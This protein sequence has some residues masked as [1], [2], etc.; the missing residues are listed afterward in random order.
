[1]R[2][3]KAEN[4]VQVCVFCGSNPGGRPA[5][6]EAARALGSALVEAG[7]GLVFGGG[8]TG[9]MGAVANR[10]L[11]AGGQVVGVIPEIFDGHDYVHYNLHE[12][13]VAADMH[14]RKAMMY[15]QAAAF[16]A[17]PGG[18]GTLE[19]LLEALTWRQLGIHGKPCGVLN[20]DGYY[21]DLLHQLQRAVDDGF[22]DAGQLDRIIV[23]TDPQKLIAGISGAIG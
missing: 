2:M 3:A 21:D 13:H 12:L 18:I 15:A 20:T 1:M 5:Y 8:S 17:L 4:R 23:E 22:L 16:I 11:E 6:L 19:E 7:F 10:V 9:L 14:A